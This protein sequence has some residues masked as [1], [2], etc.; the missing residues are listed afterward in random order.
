MI[1]RFKIFEN[2][3]YSEYKK[4]CLIRYEEGIYVIAMNLGKEFRKMYEMRKGEFEYINLQMFFTMT[5]EEMRNDLLF[6]SDDLNEILNN[7][8]LYINTEKYNL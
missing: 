7:A 6:D 8:D 1:T 5:P 4:Y 2:W 3:N